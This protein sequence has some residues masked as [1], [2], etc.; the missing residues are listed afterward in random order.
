MSAYI[1][2]RTPDGVAREVESL[3]KGGCRMFVVR[4]VGGGGMLDLERLGAAR[5]AAGLQAVVE[6]DDQSSPV[7][8]APAGAGAR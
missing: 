2:A 3:F 5:Y 1:T 7:G 6:L 8:V 4:A